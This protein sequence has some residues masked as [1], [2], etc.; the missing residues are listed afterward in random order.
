MAIDAFATEVIADG[1]IGY[2][3]LGEAP[4]SATA[5]DASGNRNDGVPSGP[6]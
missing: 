6:I 4:G 2:W 1:P 3:R 5:A